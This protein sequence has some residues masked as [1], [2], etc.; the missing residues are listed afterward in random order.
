MPGPYGIHAELVLD[1]KRAGFR[2]TLCRC[3]ASKN[4]PYCD[5]SHQHIGF[6][7]TGEPPSKD[8]P[9]LEVRNGALAIDPELDGPLVIAGNL[10]APLQGNEEVPYRA[11]ILWGL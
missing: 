9:K 2:A 7:A 4:K 6:E 1:G 3:G 8:T 10:P 5:K 11:S